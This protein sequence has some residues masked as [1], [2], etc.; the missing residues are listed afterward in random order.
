MCCKE[1]DCCEAVRVSSTF[2]LIFLKLPSFFPQHAITCGRGTG[3]F[4]VVTSTFIIIVRGSR[5][6]LWGSLYLDG[7]DEEDRDLK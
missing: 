6:C 4:L 7:Y 3:V 2:E 1:Q 5:A